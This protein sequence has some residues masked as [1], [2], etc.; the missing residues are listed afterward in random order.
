MEYIN[1]FTSVIYVYVDMKDF[2][3]KLGF[4]LGCSPQ[5]T[6]LKENFSKLLLVMINNAELFSLHMY[7][8]GLH[9]CRIT[10]SNCYSRME[11]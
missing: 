11:I 7:E 3:T 4:K 5:T 8:V 6:E 2:I 10:I 9:S 1:S